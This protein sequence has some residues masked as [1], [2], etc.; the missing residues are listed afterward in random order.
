MKKITRAFTLLMCIAMGVSASACGKKSN[1]SSED[2]VLNI[3]LYHPGGYG[4]EFLDKMGEAFAETYKSEG[5]SINI[6][7]AEKVL[8]VENEILTPKKTTTDIYFAGGF[9]IAK[10]IESSRSV[11]KN[12]DETLLYDLTDSFYNSYAIGKD[13]KAETVKIKDKIVPE[14]LQYTQYYGKIDKWNNKY[15]YMPWANSVTGFVYNKELLNSFGLDYPVTTDEMLDEFETIKNANRGISP[16]V[17]AMDNA[18]GWWDYV[19][20]VWWSQYSGTT[21][22]ENFYRTIPASGT[23]KD[24]GYEVYN[25]D[26][27]EY[28]HRVLYQM[29]RPENAPATSGGWD[30]TFAATNMLSGGSVFMITGDWIA[31]EMSREFPVESSAVTMM[32][33]PILSDVG[34]KLRLDGSTAGNADKAKCEEVL[35]A[36]V[37]LI[38]EGK[39]DD[40]I[41][42]SVGTVCGVTLNGEQ[43]E[44]LKVAR[45][46]YYNLGYNHQCVIPGFSTKK[47]IA[48]LFLKFIASDDGIE[49][50]RK[51]AKATLPFKSTKEIGGEMSEI[52]RSCASVSDY[53]YAYS[54]CEM[55]SFSLLRTS[56]GLQRFNGALS[57]VVL[58]TWQGKILTDDEKAGLSAEQIAVASAKK[59]KDAQYDWA[60]DNWSDCVK[61]AGI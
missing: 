49:I 51:Y 13:G 5:Y 2:K 54:I 31:N 56:G 8:N 55:D 3:Q 41:I 48:V 43:V 10:P 27:I 47:D 38:D 12:N 23:M 46:I 34:V 42:S 17:T 60:R 36:T 35:R 1:G 11:L 30:A 58:L 4:R 52:Q 59:F 15:F 29:L 40:E 6:T 18:Y 22:W 14:A 19:T 39:S 9:N 32:K 16:V 45:G 37:R 7:K 20:N 25:D 28:A 24:N 61:I 33:T 26:G 50:F 53:E 21:A 57:N 44:A